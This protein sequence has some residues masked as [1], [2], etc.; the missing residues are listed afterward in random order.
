MGPDPIQRTTSTDGT[1]IAGRVLGQ[2][3]PLLLVP[4]AL[5][6]GEFIWDPLLPFLTERF[7]C[8]T[9]ST[10]GRGPLNEQ[11]SDM[12]R[13]RLIEDVVSFAESI[14]EPTDVFA[15]SQ[16]GFLALGA[17]ERTGSISTLTAFE[18]FVPE[19]FTEDELAS[20][21]GVIG[22][23]GEVAAEGRMTDA[24]RT[25][26]EWLTNED[27]LSEAEA[28]G[29][30][31]GFSRNVVTQL[32]EFQAMTE[33]EIPSPTDPSQLDQITAKV[34]I[35][36]GTRSVPGTYWADGAR[37]VAEHVSG[38]QLQA[39]PGTGHFGPVCDPEAVAAALIEFL[40]AARLGS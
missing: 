9:M 3:P 8:Y 22:R 32:Q 23:M 5:S 15:W 39:I 2:G 30:F 19:A 10:R 16:G 6:D 36:H 25:F 40:G 27:E 4:G 34:Q 11:N 18:P 31:S 35:L 24:A 21:I 26:F 12:R 1:E 33:S 13:E 17:A 7:T 28:L 20:F 14:G 37:H 38:A 29:L